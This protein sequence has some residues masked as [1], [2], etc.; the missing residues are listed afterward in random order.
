MTIPSLYGSVITDVF[1]ST[2]DLAILRLAYKRM[3]EWIRRM[4][5][6]RGELQLKHPVF[7]AGSAAE[8]KER[9]GP[10]SIDAP[11]IVYTIEDDKAIDDFHRT[12]GEVYILTR[13]M[14]P[15]I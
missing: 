6:Y 3:R 1:H 11:N 5:Q 12:Q 8:C 15:L 14:L 2:S 7:P 9:D 4:S 10:V 13:D